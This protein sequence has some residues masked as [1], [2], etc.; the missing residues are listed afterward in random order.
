MKS[1]KACPHCEGIT[2]LP[3]RTDADCFHAVDVEIK[4]AVTHL[5]SLTKRKSKLLRLKMHYR[6]RVLAP[7]RRRLRP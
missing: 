5:R 2:D 6:R 7:A 1:P 4:R 3:H